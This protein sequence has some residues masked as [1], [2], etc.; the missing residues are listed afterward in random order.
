MSHA[1]Y[2]TRKIGKTTLL[3]YLA[4]KRGAM[5]RHE[6]YVHDDYRSGR[7]EILWVY[8]DFHQ[9]M[10]GKNVLQNM[11]FRLAEELEMHRRARAL[12]IETIDDDEPKRVTAA[13][14]KRLVH[15]VDEEF[16]IKVVFLLDDFDIP[17][18]DD[19]VTDED[20]NLLRSISDYASLVIA[21]DEPISEL[22]PD[23]NESSPL[24]GILR[25]ERIG[26]IDV[27][28]ARRL[29]CQPAKE[30]GVDFIAEEVNMLL[31]IGGRMPYLLT[32]TCDTY[33]EM[34]LN[35]MDV[36]ETFADAASYATIRQQLINRLLL[37]PH[38]TNG[39]NLIWARSSDVHPVLFEMAKNET[40]GVSGTLATKAELY[41]LAYPF[42][43][44]N[45][46]EYRIFGALFAAYVRSK[47]SANGRANGHHID[48]MVN[49]ILK[50]LSPV[51]R[52]VMEYLARREEQVC[53]FGELLENVWEDGTGTKRALE[54]AVHRLRRTIP[55]DYQIK[56]VRGEGYKYTHVVENPVI[57]KN[58]RR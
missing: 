25:P 16:Q 44:M 5:R 3:K 49:E 45:S 40:G 19:G 38:V 12:E 51:D 36:E 53:T 55:K 35:I 54:A 9:S 28:A 18:M 42:P 52:G 43:N 7:R 57:A 37:E 1:I 33:F 6:R 48:D 17:L 56:N 14:I 24:L 29:I 26:L 15:D 21:T 13:K 47:D 10:A 8:I 30:S 46:G 22:K 34:R 11:F 41:S 2:G 4:H 31:R 23:F 27:D 20:D 50:G 32:V 39:L 58:G